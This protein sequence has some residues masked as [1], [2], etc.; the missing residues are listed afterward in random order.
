MSNEEITV[1]HVKHTKNIDIKTVKVE[2]DCVKI[3]EREPQ[4]T[5]ECIFNVKEISSIPLL[6]R[7][8][9]RHRKRKSV[10][11]YLD[12]KPFCEKLKSSNELIEPLTDEDRKRIVQREIAKTLG[13]FQVMKNI[14]AYI[15]IGLLIANIIIHFV[16]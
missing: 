7:F 10:L 9:N 5:S 11:I 16:F 1:F 2:Q 6:G 14:F 3:P 15:I 12:G 8:I 13:K 4:F